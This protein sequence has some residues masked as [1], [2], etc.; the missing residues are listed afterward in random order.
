MAGESASGA[1]TDSFSP[2]CQV[3]GGSE[4]FEFSATGTGSGDAATGTFSVS[5]PS[6]A[7][8]SGT[9][10][11]LR[12]LPLSTSAK[13]AEMGGVVTAVSGGNSA[14]SNGAN[15]TIN[16]Y[17]EY[18]IGGGAPRD[19]FGLLTGSNN[20]DDNSFGSAGQV[21]TGQVA[22]TLVDR[23]SDG[24]SDGRDNCPGA[25]NFA[26]RD[27]DGDGVGDECDNCPG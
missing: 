14:F 17:D 25:S 2:F 8:V 20:C 27:E 24:V 22:I 16:I 5:C 4:S 18:P 3:P 7:T 11:C 21:T 19:S 6:G 15:I 10:D 13:V 26:Q 9:L 1:G 23:D 12:T